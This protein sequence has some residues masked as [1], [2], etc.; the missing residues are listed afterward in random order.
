LIWGTVTLPVLKQKPQGAK[1]DVSVT[2]TWR[3]YF[4]SDLDGIFFNEYHMKIF[5]KNG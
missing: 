4:S 1:M 3:V 5:K 2:G